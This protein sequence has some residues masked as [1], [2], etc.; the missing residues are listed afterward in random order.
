[1]FVRMDF[2]PVRMKIDAEHVKITSGYTGAEFDK[3]EIEEI[4]LIEKL[5]DEKFV[6]TN[7]SADGNQ[8]LGKFRGSKS[9]AC[10]MYVWLKETP[11]IEIKTDKYTIFINSKEYGQTEKWYEKLN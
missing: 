2:T 7:G 4:K 6:R 10:R 3:D 8:W 11:I 9:G 5:P 1:M